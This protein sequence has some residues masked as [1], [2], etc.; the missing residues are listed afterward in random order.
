MLEYKASRYHKYYTFTSPARRNGCYKRMGVSDYIKLY[1]AEQTASTS[2][3]QTADSWTLSGPGE[4][5]CCTAGLDLEPEYI[6]NRYSWSL[7]YK[8]DP[9]YQLRIFLFVLVF[10][11][12][13]C[14]PASWRF[15]GAGIR[16]G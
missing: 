14:P 12:P 2:S 13:R 4:A 1:S 8:K 6:Q 10:L 15:D 7:I 9:A 11:Y 5:T 3:Q 16:I